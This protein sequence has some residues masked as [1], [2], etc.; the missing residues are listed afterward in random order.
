MV[1]RGFKDHSSVVMSIS[2]KPRVWVGHR[3]SF[4]CLCHRPNDSSPVY[5]TPHPPVINIVTSESRKTTTGSDPSVR[6]YLNLF[7]VETEFPLDDKISPF[8]SVLWST[9]PLRSCVVPCYLMSRETPLFTIRLGTEV[10]LDFNGSQS[11]LLYN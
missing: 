9:L 1:R 5:L 8:D 6:V 11:F 3:W 2:D 10:P 7:S 4:P